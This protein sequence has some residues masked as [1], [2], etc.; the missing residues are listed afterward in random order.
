M[1]DDLPFNGDV[2][3]RF[4][5]RSSKGRSFAEQ[6]ATLLNSYHAEKIPR[7]MSSMAPAAKSPL[8]SALDFFQ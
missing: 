5:I 8:T 7:R 2:V 3:W 4:A 6:K 1:P